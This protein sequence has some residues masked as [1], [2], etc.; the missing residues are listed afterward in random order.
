GI[1]VNEWLMKE[2]YLKLKEKPE[3]IVPLEKAEVNWKKTKAWGAGGYYGRIFLNVKGREPE[4]TIKPKHYER[5][6]DELA[7]K[8]TALTD[9][10]GNPIGTRVI[11]PQDVY[12]ECR[13]IPPD[14]IVYF[15][16]LDWRSVGSVGLDRIHTF[17]NDTG[18]D[19]ANHAVNG[20]F[21]MYD[22]R[23]EHGGR[24]LEGLQLMDVAP[25]VL[26]LMGLPVPRDM[27]GKVIRVSG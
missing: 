23:G 14:L 4:G 13:N 19:D 24:K 2:G 9:E 3:G 1:C 12:P 11:K 10:K 21:I 7:A 8:L 27:E 16:D 22:P 15:G 5:V 18:P 6:R 17:E 26:D 20:I 25:T